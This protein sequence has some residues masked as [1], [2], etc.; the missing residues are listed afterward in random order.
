MKPKRK[1]VPRHARKWA[2]CRPN[3]HIHSTWDS[4]HDAIIYLWLQFGWE[5]IGKGWTV[6]SVEATR[7]NVVK[8]PAPGA[9]EK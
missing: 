7:L 9:K 3:G 8:P 6:W 5:F 4:S 1:R 2:I